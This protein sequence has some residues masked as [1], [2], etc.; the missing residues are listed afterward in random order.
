MIEVNPLV[1]TKDKK[2]IAADTKVLID[3]SALFR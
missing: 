2:I 1:Y 3:D